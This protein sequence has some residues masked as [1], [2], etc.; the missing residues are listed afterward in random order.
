MGRCHY[1]GCKL[2]ETGADRIKN[3]PVCWKCVVFYETHSI[4]L[5][6]GL[7]EALP[8]KI[9]RDKSLEEFI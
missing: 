1:C 8:K 5:R 2:N 3:K 7:I 4:H 6:R 9:M